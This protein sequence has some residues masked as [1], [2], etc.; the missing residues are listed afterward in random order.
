MAGQKLITPDGEVRLELGE[1]VLGTAPAAASG[2]AVVVTGGDVAADHARLVVSAS[3]VRVENLT[4]DASLLSVSGRPVARSGEVTSGDVLRLGS[5]EV[6]LVAGT[7]VQKRKRSIGRRLLR[8]GLWAAGILLGLAVA[9]VVFVLVFVSPG[10]VKREIV[11]AIERELGRDATIAGIDLDRLHG[12]TIRGLVI[13]NRAG[14]SEEPFLTADEVDVRVEVWPLLRSLGRD[15]RVA[16]AIRNPAVLIERSR[17]RALNID[18]LLK[19]RAGAAD[20][21]AAEEDA[22]AAE[23]MTFDRLEAALILEGGSLRFLDRLHDAETLVEG[24]TLEAKLPSLEEKLTYALALAAPEGKHPGAVRLEGSTRITRNGAFD[25]KAISG[26]VVRIT[27]EDLSPNFLALHEFSKSFAERLDAEVTVS[28]AG[29][30]RVTIKLVKA[31]AKDVDFQGLGLAETAVPGHN[32]QAKLTATVDLGSF[33][34]P[35][36]RSVEF[37][38]EAT[39]GLWQ[40]C[41]LEGSLSPETVTAALDFRADLAPLTS[42]ELASV[43]RAK[44]PVKGT[45]CLA[46]VAEGPP[47]KVAFEGEVLARGLRLDPSVTDGRT[48]APEDVGVAFRGELGLT[49]KFQPDRLRVESLRATR[50]AG[51]FLAL[52]LKRAEAGNL[53]NPKHLRARVEISAALDGSAFHRRI[54]RGFEA[55]E[56]SERLSVAFDLT[57]EDGRVRKGRLLA[58]TLERTRGPAEPITIT[59]EGGGG[60]GAPGEGGAPGGAQP[61]KLTLRSEGGRALDLK[62][63][64]TGEKVFSKERKLD[65]TFGG[66]MDLALAK[67]RL[68][69]AF[70]ALLPRPE[71][72]EG[73]KRLRPVDR[74]L[75]GRVRIEDGRFE[76]GEAKFKSSARVKVDRLRLLAPG[77][78]GAGRTVEEEKLSITVAEAVVDRTPGEDGLP[79]LALSGT[80]TIDTSGPDASV[81]ADIS[82]WERK[83]GTCHVSVKSMNV[84]NTHAFLERAGL[85]PAGLAPVK[86]RLEVDLALDTVGGA[87]ELKRLRSDT[88]LFRGSVTGHVRNLPLETL[89][90][91]AGK[92]SAREKVLAALQDAEAELRVGDAEVD[93]ARFAALAGPRLPPTVRVA[94]EG[95]AA[96]AL[97][98]SKARGREAVTWSAALD[99]ER[100]GFSVGLPALALRKKPGRAGLKLSGALRRV[101]PGDAKGA[102]PGTKGERLEL[103]LTAAQLA[104]PSLDLALGGRVAIPLPKEGGKP[105]GEAAPVRLAFTAEAGKPCDLAELGKVIRV[106]LARDLGEVKAS[107][108]AAFRIAYDGT[109]GALAD[110]SLKGA[111]L[112]GR[113]A[114]DRVACELSGRPDLALTANGSLTFSERAASAKDLT[115]AVTNR[116]AK[117]E[118]VL[119]VHRFSAAVPE[120]RRLTEVPDALALEIDAS[121]SELHLR[122]LLDAFAPPKPRPAAAAPPAAPPAAAPAGV[123]KRWWTQLATASVTGSVR[124]KRCYYDAFSVTDLEIA[125]RFKA[126]RGSATLSGKTEGGEVEAKVTADLAGEAPRC[127]LTVSAGALEL[128]P[129]VTLAEQVS[130]GEGQYGKMLYGK[131]KLRASAGNKTGALADARAWKGALSFSTDAGGLRNLA[132][133]ERVLVDRMKVSGSFA[134]G[135]FASTI[136]GT[137]CGGALW[138]RAALDYR[139]AKKLVH[140]LDLHLAGLDLDRLVTGLDTRY[141]DIFLGKASLVVRTRGTGLAPADAAG[142]SGGLA[143]AT[144]GLVL[145]RIERFPDLKVLLG[146]LVMIAGPGVLEGHTYPYKDAVFATALARGKLRLVGWRSSA[147]GEGEEVLARAEA[148][149]APFELWSAARL[150]PKGA[151]RFTSADGR[152]PSGVVAGSVEAGGRLNQDLVVRVVGLPRR[153]EEA[154]LEK[155]PASIGDRV[156]GKHL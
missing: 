87:F 58:A 70:D 124:V 114:L 29:D 120:G 20:P 144:Q 14:F 34:A 49:E 132:H 17:A 33:A 109:L 16:V 25:P 81:R 131:F 94:A 46:L 59:L 136:E 26:E 40:A 100:A 113:A 60:G 148:E 92:E 23:P 127:E 31:L 153:A 85:L 151:F 12:V 27:V 41:T 106:E 6:R 129:L 28:A 74:L 42:G 78:E 138:A 134:S 139:N 145:N 125:P 7:T 67:K 2:T 156:A 102:A 21:P 154:V 122:P 1:Y 95:T 71:G 97:S 39:S 103:E 57:A 86:G 88:D 119:V 105:D 140:A 72:G 69:G 73:K 143:L 5:V 3:G 101:G 104:A 79:R 96:L 89:A 149:K 116:K 47:G 52:D 65:F 123:A 45:V 118:A 99:L 10:R 4:G 48:A 112:S 84:E 80:V 108:G 11:A 55:P 83:L 135:R 137:G 51:A 76:G 18:D 30:G 9:L 90:R 68:A 19:K 64:G 117:R 130:G 82:D 50:A 13:R 75:A 121:A 111:T 15:V 22:A 152:A 44:K 37:G 54:G 63:E 62:A 66:S 107:G 53:A 133:P 61:F 36:F 38:G 24:I 150:D 141:G 142:W 35:E 115:L 128:A 126:G 93:L 147:V 56:I 146:P 77:P 32:A 91:L 155:L 98:V 8:A 110:G 43:T